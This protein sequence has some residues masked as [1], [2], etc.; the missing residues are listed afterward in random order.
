MPLPVF[1]LQFVQFV[2]AALHVGCNL[3]C[4]PFFTLSS[5]LPS[6]FT[7]SHRLRQNRGP[8]LTALPVMCQFREGASELKSKGQ[9]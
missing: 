8:C 5:G 3:S 9:K 7:F 4:S 1:F 6:L 2:H